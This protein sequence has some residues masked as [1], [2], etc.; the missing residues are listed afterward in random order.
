MCVCVCVYIKSTP[1]SI[2]YKRLPVGC[3][4]SRRCGRVPRL[5]VD[6]QTD[7]IIIIMIIY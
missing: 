3:L 5:K 1:F 7:L 4:G 6:G 2:I